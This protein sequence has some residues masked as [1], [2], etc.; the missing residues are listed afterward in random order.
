MNKET[1]SMLLSSANG[2]LRFD[3]KSGFHVLRKLG[4]QLDVQDAPPDERVALCGSLL[5]EM[6]HADLRGAE[7][8]RCV[9]FE[10]LFCEHLEDGQVLCV[11]DAFV[12]VEGAI[13]GAVPYRIAVGDIKPTAHDRAELARRRLA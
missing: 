13:V 1:V 8:A 11:A 5:F 10:V 3:A 7:P 4:R 9:G 6:L 2:V 12:R